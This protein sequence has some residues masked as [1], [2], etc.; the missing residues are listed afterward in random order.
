[1]AHDIQTIGQH[2]ANELIRDGMRLGII[3]SITGISRHTLREFSCTIHGQNCNQGGRQPDNTIAFVKAG[4][5]L[6]ELSTAVAIFHCVES[7]SKSPMDAFVT[8]WRAVKL[9]REGTKPRL[10]DINAAWYAIRDVK[11]HLIL[12]KR[13]DVCKA[14]YISGDNLPKTDRNCPY[15]KTMSAAKI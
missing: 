2:Y 6:L 11:A 12:W 15:C 4:Q 14:N 3:H 8:T 9:L 13:C 7:D 1:M 10:I 5:P